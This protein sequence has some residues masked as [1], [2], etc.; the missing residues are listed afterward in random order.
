MEEIIF[1]SELPFLPDGEIFTG[2][3]ARGYVENG[4]IYLSDAKNRYEYKDWEWWLNDYRCG[5]GACPVLQ[6]ENLKI[7]DLEKWNS[8]LYVPYYQ[9]N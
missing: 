9:E 1:A 7:L 2:D 8:I 4:I 3:Y 5:L 6:I